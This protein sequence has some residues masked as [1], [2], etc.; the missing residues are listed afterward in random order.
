MPRWVSWGAC[1]KCGGG[2]G[3]YAVSG[4]MH[5]EVRRRERRP[6]TTHAHR[7][8]RMLNMEGVMVDLPYPL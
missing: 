5:A 3:R 2:C 6:H 7:T 1:V 4:G 8:K